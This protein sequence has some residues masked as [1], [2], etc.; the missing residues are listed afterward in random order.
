[1]NERANKFNKK[2]IKGTSVSLL[3]NIEETEKK[4]EA[5]RYALLNKLD[6]FLQKGY[7]YSEPR[8]KPT[9]FEYIS[10]AILQG[11]S[12]RQIGDELK[13]ID[14]DEAISLVEDYKKAK[15]EGLADPKL[16]Y[17]ILV[18]QLEF[19]NSFGGQ[20]FTVFSQ[21]VNAIQD[22]NFKIDSM[23][24]KA[25][26]PKLFNDSGSLLCKSQQLKIDLMARLGM[27]DKVSKDLRAD[28][29]KLAHREAN[30][31][32]E[33]V[34]NVIKGEKIDRESIKAI[35]ESFEDRLNN[36]DFNM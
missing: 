2:I 23:G 14:L 24:D 21:A 13:C 18:E 20:A 34:T 25:A 4:L 1:M 19:F 28:Q 36:V 17:D 6:K 12:I 15:R 10:L 11:K 30:E 35:Q 33:Q 9:L 5:Q 32:R 16:G 29:S 8:V 27:Y 7:D 26:L 22:C 31:L 3:S